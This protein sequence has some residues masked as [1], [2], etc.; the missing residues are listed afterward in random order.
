MLSRK[1]YKNDF[2]PVKVSTNTSDNMSAP[3]QAQNLPVYIPGDRWEERK[4]HFIWQDII[5]MCFSG[6]LK[7]ND[8]EHLAVSLMPRIAVCVCLKYFPLIM[9]WIPVHWS[10]LTKYNHNQELIT[11]TP[12]FPFSISVLQMLYSL[13]IVSLLFCYGLFFF[14]LSIL[15]YFI[16]MKLNNLG[17]HSSHLFLKLIILF[18]IKEIFE[19][20]IQVLPP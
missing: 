18:L 16:F 1:T 13:I 8:N 12:W 3:I 9:K 20:S 6:A 4:Y 14:N 5:P 2:L 11:R 17:K 10:K 19:F 15:R 7:L